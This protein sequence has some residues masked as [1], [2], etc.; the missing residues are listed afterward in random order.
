MRILFLSQFFW[1]ETRT[2]PMNLAEM[3]ADLQSRGHEVLVITG[4]PN[5]PHGRIYD[6]YQQRLWQW[7]E[8][9]GVRLLRLPLYPDHSRSLLKRLLSFGSFT[10]SS[11]TLGPLLG[12]S[13][14]PDV[15]FVYFAPLTIG[16]SAAWLSRLFNAPLVYWITDLW[17]ENLR[18]SGSRINDR[19]YG[20]LR[21]IED[22]GYRRSSQIC[23]DSPGFRTNLLEKGVPD[24]K[25]HVVA[26]WAEE[27]IFFPVPQDTHLAETYGFAGKFNIVYGGNFGAVQ[28]L[29][30]VVQAA[31]RLLDLP[32]IQFVFIGDGTE[33][34]RLQRLVAEAELPN[35]RF[36][37]RQPMETIHRF[38]ALADVLLVHLKDVPIFRLQ[39]PSKVI[40]Y[41]ACGRPIL[42]AVPGAAEQ[43][44][45]DAQAGLSCASE[46]A[47]ALAGRVRDFYA[48]SPEQRQAMGERG[49]SAYLA[50][51]TRSV[52]VGRIEQILET[53]VQAGRGEK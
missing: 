6:G 38:F 20:M 14:K 1:P 25:I 15:L 24:T 35:V 44:V 21:R 18:A 43:V 52:Q 19:A 50:Q 40:A 22:W 34:E 37:P 42:C 46:D 26:E 7:D 12:H 49:R 32:E 28:G 16:W 10:F 33:L 5:H 41:L 8:Y 17:P 31:G 30:T 11:A 3:A 51:Y 53:V 29:D 39:L 45:L 47:D 9:K 13:F 4:F 36:I 23:V 48:L 2:A 27:D